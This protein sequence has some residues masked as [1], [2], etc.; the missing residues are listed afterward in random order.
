MA[1]QIEIITGPMFAGKTEEL[2]RRLTRVQ[3]AGQKAIVFKPEIDNRYEQ[4]KVCSHSGKQIDCIVTNTLNDIWEQGQNYDV[5]AIDEIQFLPTRDEILINQQHVEIRID[6]LLNKLADMGKRIIV[7]GLDLDFRGKPFVNTMYIMAI[8]E[9][10]D[11]LTA[12]CM[13]CGNLATRSQRLIDGKP[14]HYLDPIIVVGAE[15]TYEAR[16]RKCH[17]VV[18]D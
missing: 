15:E 13:Q 14:A 7:T 8:A 18:E 9:K 16:C 17:A 5:I 4:N 12:I 3:Y 6:D 10:V 11:K 2:I 1:G